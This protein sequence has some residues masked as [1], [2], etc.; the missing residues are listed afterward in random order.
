[1]NNFI[2]KTFHNELIVLIAIA[3]SLF[4]VA[5]G[6]GGGSTSVPALVPDTTAPTAKITF[7]TGQ[8]LSNGDSI[9]VRGTASDDSD[10][11]SVTVNGIAVTT[12]DNFATW[13]IVLPL[14][15]GINTITVAT[16]DVELNTDSIAAQAMIDSGVIIAS[17]ER[18]ILDSGNNRY[19]ITDIS[20]RAIVAIDVTTGARIILSDATTPNDTNAFVT[21][22]NKPGGQV[23]C[24]MYKI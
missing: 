19:L 1:M 12:T 18:I 16:R 4:L 10:V 6:G 15:P 21:P 17:P 5:C 3:M 13:S 24:I 23:A 7:P 14:T 11:D 2:K 8:S 22:Q 20:L 9:I